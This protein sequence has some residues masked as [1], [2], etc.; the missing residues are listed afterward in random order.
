V[1]DPTTAPI[2]RRIFEAIAGGSTLRAL[3][4]ALTL[5]G[6]ATPTGRG[7]VWSLP[8]L[9]HI[10]R[11]PVY[12]G[13]LTALRYQG[14]KVNGTWRRVLRPVEEQRVL[15]GV[16]PAIV[17]EATFG[18]ADACLARNKAFAPRNNRHP[19]AALLRAGFARCG[20]CDRAM[21]AVWWSKEQTW[22]YQCTQR[23][24]P[25]QCKP[26]PTYLAPQLDALV[27][28]RVRAVLLQPEIIAREVARL[29]DADPTAAN[30]Q[31]IDRALADVNRQ[32]RNLVD[33][34]ARL[35]AAVADVVA[36]KLT[37]LG[38]Q[39]AR[40]EAERAQLLGERDTWQR[41]QDRLIELTTW[42][43]TVAANLDA[44]TYDERRMALE[45]L[46]V[47]VQVW[48]SDH[49]PRYAITA[50]IPFLAAL[51]GRT[52]PRGSSPGR[53]GRASGPLCGC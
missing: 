36:D 1:L 34:I 23:V 37:A 32:Q 19:T 30:L 27:W 3:A 46:G 39:R 10:L 7:A 11:N 9:R 2:V 25:A 51:N 42:C 13:R 16:A 48:P 22:R 38:T 49:T 47:Q 53:A 18:A 24:G 35:G 26:R 50:S 41:T 6:I 31:A 20:F 33:Q 45:A 21:I 17:D 43:R 44:L 4:T 15:D 29:A 52:T 28:A 12:I 8:T 5:E 40:L 14:G